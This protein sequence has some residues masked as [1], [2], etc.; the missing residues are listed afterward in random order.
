ME[1]CFHQGIKKVIATFY[2]TILTFFPHEEW[3]VYI[4]QLRVMKSE[5]VFFYSMKQASNTSKTNSHFWT[6]VFFHD[7]GFK[8]L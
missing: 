6:H 2:L 5:I 1:A 3:Q 4:S 7:S 8:Y